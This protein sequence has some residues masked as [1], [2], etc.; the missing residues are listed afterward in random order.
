MMAT[1]IEFKWC[2]GQQPEDDAPAA[3]SGRAPAGSGLTANSVAD[4][5]SNVFRMKK[6]GFDVSKHIC[7]KKGSDDT[8]KVITI[9]EEGVT[10]QQKLYGAMVG[11]DV[12]MAW[13]Q[14]PRRPWRQG[15]SYHEYTSVMDDVG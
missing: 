5:K 15:M 7:R 3:A 14:P 8:Y 2:S 10:A 6:H 1:G 12:S 11:D 13:L 9:S 4:M